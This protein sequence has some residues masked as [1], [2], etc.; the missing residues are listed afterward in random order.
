GFED[1]DSRLQVADLYTD[2]RD[3]T[4]LFC[5]VC[6]LTA[7]PVPEAGRVASS[8]ESD[9]RRLIER[10]KQ[11]VQDN[12]RVDL[13]RLDTDQVVQGRPKATLGLVWT[14]LQ[15]WYSDDSES[16]LLEWCQ[17]R[18]R[19]YAGVHIANL[20][21]SWKDGLG[22]LA[23]LHSARSH[24]LA[25]NERLKKP[26]ADNLALAFHLAKTE[27]GVPTLLD[28]DDLL[29]SPTP[30]KKSVSVYLLLMRENV[31][32]SENQSPPESPLSAETAGTAAAAAAE[33]HLEKPA[34]E[35]RKSMQQQQQQLPLL[36]DYQHS[37]ERC[38]EWLFDAEDLVASA[39]D[40]QDDDNDDVV[41]NDELNSNRQQPADKVAEPVSE[42]ELSTVREA[43]RQYRDHEA[44]ADQLTE[45]QEDVRCVLELADALLTSGELSGPARKEIQSQVQLLQ[46]RWDALRQAAVAKEARLRKRLAALQERD[47]RR[48]SGF[49]HWAEGRIEQETVGGVGP[50]VEDIKRQLRSHREF[51][52]YLE[53]QEALVASVQD[54]LV[55]DAD[56]NGESG[57]ETRIEGLAARWTDTMAYN[58]E[59]FS[60]L[61]SALLA[62]RQFEED[63][64]LLRDVVFSSDTQ[65]A[66]VKSLSSC[67]RKLETTAE[68]VTSAC[69]DNP[70]CAEALRQ[71]LAKWKA[72]DFGDLKPAMPISA[73]G[74]G[75]GGDS[76]GEDLGDSVVDDL[77][78]K[79]RSLL[80]WFDRI[81][82]MLELTSL[83]HS[84]RSSLMEA[85]RRSLHQQQSQQDSASAA[86][87]GD[88]AEKLSADQHRLLLDDIR[89]E[90]NTWE[91]RLVAV[92]QLGDSCIS[93]GRVPAESALEIQE[94]LEEIEQRWTELSA[95]WQD[96]QRRA[97]VAD[98]VR[99]FYECL[100]QLRLALNRQR[101]FLQSAAGQRGGQLAPLAEAA[102]ERLAE[103]KFSADWLATFDA[104]A[105]L[106]KR[107]SREQRDP[108]WRLIGETEAW[109]DEVAQL[110]R[111]PIAVAS[112]EDN[113][114][115]EEGGGLTE[116]HRHLTSL[117]ALLQRRGGESLTRLEG[118]AADPSQPDRQTAA[119][120][121]IRRLSDL[122]SR[123]ESRAKFVGDL[124]AKRAKICLQELENWSMDMSEFAKHSGFESRA[125]LKS[126]LAELD[127]AIADVMALAPKAS[128]VRDLVGE[129]AA[130]CEESYRAA[131]SARSESVANGLAPVQQRLEAQRAEL[132][133][134]LENFAALQSMEAWCDS[135]ESRLSAAAA[136]ADSASSQQQQQQQQAKPRS[137]STSDLS[138]SGQLAAELSET[139][140]SHLAN[141]SDKMP[142]SL[143]ARIQSII[144]Q[145]GQLASRRKANMLTAVHSFHSLLKLEKDW[146]RKANKQV[147]S[148][149]SREH[150]DAEDYCTDLER[151][152]AVNT[153]Y[154]DEASS[155]RREQLRSLAESLN[156]VNEEASASVA[157]AKAAADAAAAAE[158][159]P[160]EDD[161]NDDDVELK[162]K[163]AVESFEDYTRELNSAKQRVEDRMEV[164]SSSLDSIQDLERRTN[165]MQEW[166]PVAEDFMTNKMEAELLAA[167]CPDEAER[168][169]AEI[170]QHRETLNKLDET[171]DRHMSSGNKDAAL[172]LEGVRDHLRASFDYV[173][174]LLN[175]F[176]RPADFEPKLD[177]VRRELESLNDRLHLLDL[178]S[179]E[180][181]DVQRTKE[182]AE[183][184]SAQLSE[185]Q[186]DLQYVVATGKQLVEQ[187]QVDF[188]KRLLAELGR[189]EGLFDRLS[190]QVQPALDKLAK[191]LPLVESLDAE[192]QQLR[193]WL[194]AA[195]EFLQQPAKEAE[196]DNGS[197]AQTCRDLKHRLDNLANQIIPAI[198]QRVEALGDLTEDLPPVT[199]AFDDIEQLIV[200]FETKKF[201]IETRI[202]DLDFDMEQQQQ[203]QQQQQKL[204]ERKESEATSADVEDVPIDEFASGLLD[205]EAVAG[206][207]SAAMLKL[208]DIGGRISEIEALV[209]ELLAARESES[210]RAAAL[211]DPAVISNLQHELSEVRSRVG[212]VRDAAAS[213]IGAAAQHGSPTSK[214]Q[215]QQPSLPQSTVGGAASV[216]PADVSEAAAVALERLDIVD[217]KLESL[218]TSDKSADGAI[219][220]SM[221]PQQ[222]VAVQ[223]QAP[224]SVPQSP[225]TSIAVAKERL[226]V[227]RGQ[228][229]DLVRG[230]QLMRDSLASVNS[231]AQ[232]RVQA[233]IFSDFCN[234]FFRGQFGLITKD[235]GSA[236]AE[237]NAAYP[238]A[239]VD[240]EAAGFS[241]SDGDGWV[242]PNILPP[243]VLSHR[244]ELLQLQSFW[245]DKIAF[246]DKEVSFLN[247]TH[248][249]ATELVS[250]QEQVASSGQQPASER[251]IASLTEQLQRRG[252]RDL[253]CL[254]WRPPATAEP[255][256]T[257]AIASD[258]AKAS[259]V[260]IRSTADSQRDR[261]AAE[262]KQRLQRLT[263][264]I[265]QRF[266]RSATAARSRTSSGGS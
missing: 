129:L 71:K 144:D 1:P 44:I 28:V 204:H 106:H 197:S 196:E 25:F 113:D 262:L 116:R 2:L 167:D 96:C 16:S 69:H 130:Y 214:Q 248:Q 179:I 243:S 61:Q 68:E 141:Y 64:S 34:E 10:S 80:D 173:A 159:E 164:L 257:V 265:G 57:T 48:L 192:L 94:L 221:S 122:A 228:I 35:T 56:A 72:G 84:A 103:M 85:S 151:L 227:I 41:D 6:Y 77:N 264:S 120:A 193:S 232:I 117:V 52:D 53:I 253:D 29:L 49:L 87:S 140:R 215:Q 191:A 126:Q 89:D 3:G 203:Q 234:S 176:Q 62:W 238:S 46:T 190:E 213:L 247:S 109:C 157:A 231:V 210:G 155:S 156:S 249:L 7:N 15:A 74:G 183:S 82:S 17:E 39:A 92:R 13:S 5:L 169:R 99:G 27:F 245:R 229:E 123:A 225:S 224:S 127:G 226:N 20:T 150:L 237:F 83:T 65:E 107:A 93:Q 137:V 21:V 121:L 266:P 114:G 78:Y 160:P 119:G 175:R 187:K 110:L 19:G 252:F 36:R 230:A 12:F 132:C 43:R 37:L 50:F 177:R 201:A 97:A 251:R 188:P 31:F 139:G 163:K 128:A 258:S 143:K 218:L 67:V 98:R 112:D 178:L 263:D 42:S 205:D 202:S 45:N 240:E 22:F 246:L 235:I 88:A 135:S 239:S 152:E 148:S 90:L 211:V 223:N 136:A 146:I 165:A 142:D 33:D 147:D 104:L 199:D 66:K 244:H 73:G 220:D 11:L 23:I 250:L 60:D 182:F 216:T 24:L 131:L 26:P 101:D 105:E 180:P 208:D 171:Y 254:N 138:N 81:E 242:S 256:S 70:K 149:M 102:A 63:E 198:L 75:S 133:A 153:S 162:A 55:L 108:L 158:E 125:D 30:D 59:R 161:A 236:V 38:L 51:Q 8:T 145:A 154:E 255:S 170:D 134:R 54:A 86:A 14:V 186:P 124:V 212:E 91:P 168:L 184:V 185:L 194:E 260:R 261:L 189:L 111:R 172:R 181:E 58:S 166:L 100:T 207:A 18:C 241:E 4:K 259:V 9:A 219:E 217:E 32:A 47:I 233:E 206:P 115:D 209:E 174:K 200:Q 40:E 79:V 195:D 76:A 222:S 118:L 95:V